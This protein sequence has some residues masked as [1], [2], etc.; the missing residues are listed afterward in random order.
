MQ[1][2]KNSNW[3]SLFPALKE[4]G[5]VVIVRSKLRRVGEAF[6]DFLI[7]VQE[8]GPAAKTKPAKAQLA[9]EKLFPADAK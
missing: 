6:A 3:E 5:I 8:V 9:I 1:L 7:P 4:L 2:G